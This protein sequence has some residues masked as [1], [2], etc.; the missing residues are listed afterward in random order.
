MISREK[1]IQSILRGRSCQITASLLPAFFSP[2]NIALCKYWGKRDV[3]LNLP[4]TSSLSISLGDRGTVTQ[5]NVTSASEDK[6][7]L[8]GQLLD[9]QHHFSVRLIKF[10]NLF[11]QCQNNS[12]KTY[13]EVRTTSNIPIAAGLASSASGF[14]SIVQALNQLFGW[15][16]T[17]RELSILARLGSGSASRSIQEGF[18][19]WH[20]GDRD[21]GLDSY[22]EQLPVVMPELCIGLLV[23]NEKSKRISS[24][25]AM[26]CTV[27]TSVYYPAWVQKTETDLPLMKKAIEANQITSL[28]KIAESNALAM[29]ACMQVAEPAIFYSE[30]ETVAA[31]HKVWK[32]R[33]EGL[34]LYFT[35]DAGPNLKLIFSTEDEEVI[36][37]NFPDVQIIKPFFR[38]SF[39][40]KQ[41][42]INS[43]FPRDDNKAE[44]VTLVNQQ[45][46][47]IGQAEKL[48][49]HQQ[50]LCHRAF[51]IF[52]FRQMQ[53]QWEL[54]LQQRNPQKYHAGG[55]WT[56]TCCGHPRPAENLL[57]AAKRRLQEE[58]GLSLSI[59]K[60]DV[61]HYR[62]EFENGL[63]E[64]EIDHVFVGFWDNQQLN[65]DSQEISETL[66][67]NIEKVYQDL[68]A[69]PKK[70]TPWFQQALD[71]AY[72]AGVLNRENIIK[73]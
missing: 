7:Y 70:Y 72:Q 54:L 33:D 47:V 44:Y 53:G 67:L 1:I 63:V 62:A 73:Q 35:Q 16:L 15:H 64:N 71:I 38:P 68:Y 46:Q 34:N 49:A 43:C 19:Y 14:A 8:A 25:L 57:E 61:F 3:N 56:N 45:D 22:A 37:Q 13:F 17:M 24:S 48:I 5:I 50:A 40:Q 39:A 69:Y 4:V 59:N 55:L 10:L 29:H 51:S 11:R 28:G 6:I 66:W 65:V 30:P 21:D 23:F 32:L 60:V 41:E 20:K 12:S 42:S 2:A 58:V 26:K 27:E 31:I 52:I 36:L 18:C 9:N